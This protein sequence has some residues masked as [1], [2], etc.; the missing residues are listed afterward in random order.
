MG[1]CTDYFLSCV[2]VTFLAGQ[3]LDLGVGWASMGRG[4]SHVL[5]PHACPSV[6][7]NTEYPKIAFCFLLLGGGILGDE[8]HSL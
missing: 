3:T 2:C 7:H 4:R 1:P 5:I 6:L 8:R